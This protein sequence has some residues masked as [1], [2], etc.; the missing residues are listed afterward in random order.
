MTLPEWLQT[1]FRRISAM[2]LIIVAVLGICA[3]AISYFEDHSYWKSKSNV[4]L[5]QASYHVDTLSIR[6]LEAASSLFSQQFPKTR[7]AIRRINDIAPIWSYP[8]SWSSISPSIPQSLKLETRSGSYLASVQSPMTEVF[9]R[10]IWVGLTFILIMALLVALSSIL[11]R[12]SIDQLCEEIS[13]LSEEGRVSQFK[14]FSETKESIRR[15]RT[16]S[17]DLRVDAE[18][19]RS[20]LQLAHDI[21][22]PIGA[23][24]ML[25][26]SE[27]IPDEERE[28]VRLSSEKLVWISGEILAT[29]RKLQ[30][31]DQILL[32]KNSIEHS[33][34]E[35]GRA[36]HFEFESLPIDAISEADRDE[37]FRHLTNLSINAVEASPEG[38]VVHLHSYSTTNGLQVDILDHG[39]GIPESILNRLNEQLPIFSTKPFGN[40]LGLRY[41]HDWISRKQ[42]QLVSETIWNEHS[43]RRMHRLSI[44][45]P[46]LSG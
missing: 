9:D 28:L 30:F 22:S 12:G 39:P 27:R 14:E 34:L 5:E 19:G 40:G 10:T 24:K 2:A 29:K 32:L 7:F 8:L 45:L 23:L 36:V 38:G 25:S 35:Q 20:Y 44:R 6:Q 17:Q 42:G 37:F 26:K 4:W 1:Q 13:T 46:R 15:L 18:V 21:R 41:A 16:Q 43:N 3:I 33:I 11:H 31:S